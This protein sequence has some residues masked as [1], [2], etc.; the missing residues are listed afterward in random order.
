[1][2]REWLLFVFVLVIGGSV[3]IASGLRT[4]PL[5]DGDDS[6]AAERRAWRTILAPLFAASI[7][8]AAVIGWA[9]VEPEDA[10]VMPLLWFL[11]ALPLA[12]VWLRA[13]I[14]SIRAALPRECGVAET[15]GFLRPRVRISARLIEALDPIA[16]EAAV[17]HEEAHV[18]HRDPLR[19]WFAQLVTDL[20]ATRAARRRFEQWLVALEHARDDEARQHGI[21]GE[22][23][24]AAMIAAARLQ[25]GASTHA[26]AR[27]TGADCAL[28]A[29]VERLLHPL[30]AP[31]VAPRRPVSVRWVLGWCGA[32]LAGALVGEHVVRVLLGAA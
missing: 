27:L 13:V 7:A 20:Q 3:L 32:L 28:R 18:R 31:T 25:V 19:I 2:D 10:E 5:N 14:R 26:G 23:L 16:I 6:F 15:H 12:V 1:M 9:V 21:E 11:A 8:I 17:A 29:R 24:A 22:D 4:L 30:P